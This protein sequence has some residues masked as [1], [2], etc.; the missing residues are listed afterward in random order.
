[1]KSLPTVPAN[2]L[3]NF[4]VTTRCAN[5][6]PSQLVRPTIV[7]RVFNATS[8]YTNFPPPHVSQLLQTKSVKAWVS[9]QVQG[10][11]NDKRRRSTVLPVHAERY[12]LQCH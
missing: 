2:Q 12:L 11:S 6:L 10:H 1:M 4:K 8:P 5:S 7:D 3:D 9:R